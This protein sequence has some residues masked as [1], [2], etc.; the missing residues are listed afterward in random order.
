MIHWGKVPHGWSPNLSPREA[1]GKKFKMLGVLHPGDKMFAELTPRSAFRCGE[2][3]KPTV[4]IKHPNTTCTNGKVQA[5]ITLDEIHESY[6][7][8]F[9][10][11]YYA[12]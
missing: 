4:V 3:N 8:S 12:Y 6:M 5:D 7:I 10:N 9:V 11:D 1:A 2:G